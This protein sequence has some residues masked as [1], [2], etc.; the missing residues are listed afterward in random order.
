M[1]NVLLLNLMPNKIETENHFKNIF[2]KLSHNV[3]ISFMRMESYESKNIPKSYLLENYKTLKDISFDDYDRFICTGSPVETLPFEKVD[4]WEELI[5]V[6][7]RIK[8]HNIKSYYICWGAQAV[9]YYRYGID[10]VKL[11]DKKFGLYEYNFNRN[12]LHNFYFLKEKIKI[13][14]SR[15]T[16]SIDAQIVNNSD[17][18]I[19]LSHKKEGI[20][21]LENKSL[22]EIYNFNHFEYDTLTLKNEYIRDI[23]KKISIDIPKNYF[24]NDDFGQDPINSWTEN[25][26]L[27]FDKWFEKD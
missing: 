25:A 11:K 18:S 1:K 20:C 2:S 8:V 23:N 27:F 7:D 22:S 24:P 21:M 26:I 17:L 13:P 12:N 4:Y 5:E 9:L 6:F 15:Y 3:K 19:V 16:E 14:V 10:K